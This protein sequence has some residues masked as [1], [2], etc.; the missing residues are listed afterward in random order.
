MTTF[1]MIFLTTI[2]VLTLAVGTILL[3]V[4]SILT[5]GQAKNFITRF[6]SRTLG[7][8]VLFFAGV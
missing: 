7:H 6:F 2:A 5:L 3:V 8:I 1:R 4:C